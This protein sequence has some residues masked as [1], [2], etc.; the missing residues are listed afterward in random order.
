[1]GEVSAMDS[2]ELQLAGWKVTLR[3]AWEVK[4]IIVCAYQRGT[5]GHLFNLTDALPQI[6][7]C[8]RTLI[9]AE[10]LQTDVTR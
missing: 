4:M 8:L 6:G 3:K 5:T 9:K 7:L 2:A 10:N 1:M